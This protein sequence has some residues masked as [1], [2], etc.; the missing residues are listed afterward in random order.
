[1]L[2]TGILEKIKSKTDTQAEL[3]DLLEYTVRNTRKKILEAKVL[4]RIGTPFKPLEVGLALK[5]G[6]LT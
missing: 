2:I 3:N 5:T 6:E 4:L 1:M